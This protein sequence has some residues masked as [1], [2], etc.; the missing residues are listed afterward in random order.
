MKILVL[1][2]DNHQWLIPGF[3]HQWKK[4]VNLNVPV[5]VCG[6]TPPTWEMPQDFEFISIGNYGEYPVDK[7]SDAVIKLINFIGEDY[8]TIFLEDYWLIRK[9]PVQIL[10]FAHHVAMTD[11]NMLRFDL[12]SDR[13][14]CGSVEELGCWENF[15]IIKA[16]Q[17][18][19][20]VSTQAGLWRC[21]NLLKMLREHES[22]W[23][24]E[25][26]GTGRMATP[27]FS[28]LTVYG[29]RQWPFRY[30]IMM[31]SGKLEKSGSWMFPPRQLALTDWNELERLGMTQPA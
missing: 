6:F 2:S 29:T 18:Q 11:P 16:N 24:F 26:A 25:M 22:P 1:T 3:A 9:V 31:R 4:Y 7:W 20:Q 30:Q 5:F 23:E 8:V 27:Q 21:D 10:E 15:D 17:T 12:T 28:H 19:Y 13:Q 14:Y